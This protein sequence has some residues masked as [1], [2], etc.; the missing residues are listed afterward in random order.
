MGVWKEHYKLQG[1]LR[2]GDH[3]R[4]IE[5]N[6]RKRLPYRHEQV[7]VEVKVGGID[8]P[9]IRFDVPRRTLK[10]LLSLSLMNAWPANKN[11][12]FSFELDQPEEKKV[13]PHSCSVADR[14]TVYGYYV[15]IDEL[16]TWL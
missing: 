16:K 5:Q 1:I 8:G 6:N 13:I 9:R 4:V 12:Q 15:E 10:P 14:W 3:V 2:A 7:C 11:Q